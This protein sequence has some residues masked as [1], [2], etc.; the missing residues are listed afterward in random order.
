MALGG[1]LDGSAGYTAPMA[2]PMQ[3]TMRVVQDN[4]TEVIA[5]TA[6]AASARGFRVTKIGN[7]A[8]DIAGTPSPENA[9]YCGTVGTTT[10]TS[11]GMRRDAIPGSSRYEIFDV[12][13]I[14]GTQTLERKFGLSTLARMEFA[15]IPGNM[16]RVTVNVAYTIRRDL[17][18]VDGT[19]KRDL[20]ANAKCDMTI[21]SV[22]LDFTAMDPEKRSTGKTLGTV[23]LLEIPVPI[24]SS[25][26]PVPRPS[27][28]CH[29][30]GN[31]EGE[32]LALALRP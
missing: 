3:D 2:A 19:G 4:A 28:A 5:R 31:F 25:G 6:R 30:T 17:S 16:T 13:T 9:L 15:D 23:D 7:N 14:E 1:C 32:L 20:C 10:N 18:A 24:T 8:M 12:A 22:P 11:S 26:S 27:L 21:F 29:A